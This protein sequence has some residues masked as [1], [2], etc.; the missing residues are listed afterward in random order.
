MKRCIGNELDTLLAIR[1]RVRGNVLS[2]YDI[3]IAFRK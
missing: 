2:V 3:G 1:S